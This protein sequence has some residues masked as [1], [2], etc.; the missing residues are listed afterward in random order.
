[1]KPIEKRQE[2]LQQYVSDMLAVDKHIHEAIRRQRDDDDLK[3]HTQA[4]QVIARL[5]EVLD[6]QINDLER[7]L[8]RLGG[9]TGSPVKD[10]VS[11]A[12][13]AVAGMYDKMRPNTAS[14]MLRDDYTALGLAA[15]SYTMLH[16]T[17]LALQDHPT[18]DLALRH[19][20]MLT[21]IITE[22]SRTIPMV[23]AVELVEADEIDV[24][25]TV[26][27]QAVRQTQEAWSSEVINQSPI[28]I[29]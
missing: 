18:A 5:E 3:Q 17:G 25:T 23:V 4:H 21:P 28:A 1:M 24:D 15:I 29:A 8:E 26:G 14:R 22:I 20:R 13:G 10:A 6:Q 16:T 7:H 11:S 9:S 2:A 12:L 19:L 27:P